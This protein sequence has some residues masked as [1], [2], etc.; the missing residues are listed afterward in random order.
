MANFPSEAE[1]I[2][3][4]DFYNQAAEALLERGA[5]NRDGHYLFG[6]VKIVGNEP[7]DTTNGR[8]KLTDYYSGEAT[9]Y[10][11]GYPDPGLYERALLNGRAILLF[12]FLDDQK[13]EYPFSYTT[14]T[15]SLVNPYT[16]I[17]RMFYPHDHAINPVTREPF[18]HPDIP[19]WPEDLPI[20]VRSVADASI[21]V[22]DI[23]GDIQLQHLTEAVRNTERPQ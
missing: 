22:M 17:G 13:R 1:N 21:I 23:A 6:P 16:T 14:C 11:A 18:S 4:Q 20:V 9:G 12:S 5:F 8:F 19:E 3:H 7:E 2:R 10:E 15:P